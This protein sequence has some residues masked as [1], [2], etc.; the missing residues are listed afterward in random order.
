[1]SIFTFNPQLR[2]NKFQN[3]VNGSPA[4]LKVRCVFKVS[5]YLIKSESYTR[6]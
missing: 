5:R 6:Q 4:L 1:M 3:E 2:S